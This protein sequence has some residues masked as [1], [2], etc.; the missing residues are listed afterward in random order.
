MEKKPMT[1]GDA[2]R[3]KSNAYRTGKNQDSKARAQARVDKDKQV[4]MTAL[5]DLHIDMLVELEPIDD[6]IFE[7]IIEPMYTAGEMS[8]G[9]FKNIHDGG[10]IH[11]TFLFTD[12]RI[13]VINVQESTGRTNISFLPYKEIR[14]FSVGIEGTELDNDLDDLDK[15]LEIWSSTF[16]NLKF[17]FVGHVNISH[18]CRMISECIVK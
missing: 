13:F 9:V 10:N 12:K 2:R 14:T 18:I 3:I 15:K 6:E 11:D 7:H 1:P 16:G 8:L 5:I 17:I 4:K